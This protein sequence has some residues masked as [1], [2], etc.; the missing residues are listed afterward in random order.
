LQLDAA[1]E[2]RGEESPGNPPRAEISPIQAVPPAEIGERVGRFER[3]LNLLGGTFVRCLSVD[4]PG[5]ILE[6]L[7]QRGIQSIATWSEEYYPKDLL[8]TLRQGE[9]T[10]AQAPDPTVRAGLTGA[11]I[12]IAET[13]SVL[14]CSGIGRPLTASLL[15]EVHMVVLHQEDIIDNLTEALNLKELQETSSAAIITGPSRTADIEMTLTI[16]VHG[17]GEL[18][19]FCLSDI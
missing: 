19:V 13:G 3:E 6:I 18:I 16:G 14:V 12:A 8:E 1:Q 5:Q 9:I 10:I 4:L 15:P 7:R 11:S 17:P 2:V